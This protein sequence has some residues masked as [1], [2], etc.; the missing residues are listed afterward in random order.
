MPVLYII[1][2]YRDTLSSTEIL[3]G[4]G[5]SYAASLPSGRK[6]LKAVTLD[7]S[8]FVVGELTSTTNYEYDLMDDIL[9]YNGSSNIWLNAGKMRTSRR[10]YSVALLTDISKICP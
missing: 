7:N 9:Q 3:L 4:S 10:D 1:Y 8:V 5:W 6:S 2:I